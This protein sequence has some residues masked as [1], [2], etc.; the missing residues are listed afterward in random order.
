MFS[1]PLGAVHLFNA[2]VQEVLAKGYYLT[3]SQ[4]QEIILG[5]E[6]V[7]DEEGISQIA[8][9]ETQQFT[10]K[11]IS[12]IIEHG[13]ELRI[14]PTIFVGGGSILLKQ[15]I[16]DIKI[17]YVEIIED[18]FANARGFEMLARQILLKR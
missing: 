10:N 15:Y 4:I 9:E 8:R 18:T 16:N 12:N 7:F 17:G 11:L 6:P 14:N 2:I 13:L 1:L 5:K 3:E